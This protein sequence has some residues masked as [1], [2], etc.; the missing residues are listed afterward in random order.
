MSLAGM[1]QTEEE[2]SV[3]F[4]W[5]EEMGSGVETDQ[6]AGL[7]GSTGESNQTD[8][9]LLIFYLLILFVLL[10]SDL[11]RTMG[12][13]FTDPLAGKTPFYLLDA[14]FDCWVEVVT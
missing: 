3:V 12:R 8:S 1:K 2:L 9:I 10:W 11:N 5:P 14:P 4:I 13:F 6:T 7:T